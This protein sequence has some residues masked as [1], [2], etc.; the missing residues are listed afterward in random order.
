LLD[1]QKDRQVEQQPVKVPLVGRSQLCVNVV[2]YLV[3][4]TKTMSRMVRLVV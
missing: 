1:E 2:S 4:A 3:V